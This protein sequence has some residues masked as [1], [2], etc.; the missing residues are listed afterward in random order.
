MDFFLRLRRNNESVEEECFNVV[1]TVCGGYIID[2]KSP[3]DKDDEVI[4]ARLAALPL[5]LLAEDVVP[6]VAV[7]TC[8]SSESESFLAVASKASHDTKR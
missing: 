6:L 1:T 4:K 2:V 8:P 3:D 5:L 7:I